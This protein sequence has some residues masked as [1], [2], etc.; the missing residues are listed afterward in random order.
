MS[1]EGE[2]LIATS[3]MTGSTTEIVG[4]VTAGGAVEDAVVDT[5]VDGQRVTTSAEETWVPVGQG[6]Q[7]ASLNEGVGLM[8]PRSVV[9][10]LK[11]RRKMEILG[12]PK[13]NV[14]FL[15]ELSCAQRTELLFRNVIPRSL[16]EL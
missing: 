15:P 3:A 10:E 14:P 1:T 2:D 13:K 8:L 11:R 6:L 7:V 9:L 4:G 16:L 5:V 12:K